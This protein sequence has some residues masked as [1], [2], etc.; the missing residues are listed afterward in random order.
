MTFRLNEVSGSAGTLDTLIRVGESPFETDS[1]CGVVP[2]AVTVDE[3]LLTS[4]LN[5]TVYVSPDSVAAVAP[6][7]LV[8]SSVLSPAPGSTTRV[9]KSVPAAAATESESVL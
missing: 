2:V 3:H 6:R 5:V 7:S 9:A 1:N 8:K 4:L